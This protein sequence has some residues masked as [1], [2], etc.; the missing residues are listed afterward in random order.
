MIVEGPACFSGASGTPSSA[1]ILF[2]MSS[3]WWHALE[4]GGPT[5]AKSSG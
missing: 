4:F 1:H 3:S 5:T 2:S